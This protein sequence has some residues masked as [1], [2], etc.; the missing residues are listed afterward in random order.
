MKLEETKIV[1]QTDFLE[2][3]N[4]YLQNVWKLVS[5]HLAGS[6]EY[7]QTTIFSVAWTTSEEPVYP[8]YKQKNSETVESILNMSKNLVRS[9]S[10]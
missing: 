3:L 7:G 2:A 4:F 5:T 10:K 9:E 8:K 1:E 6:Q